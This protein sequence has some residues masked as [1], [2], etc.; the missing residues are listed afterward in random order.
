MNLSLVHIRLSL[1]LKRTN[2]KLSE[3]K[4]FLSL[5]KLLSEIRPKIKK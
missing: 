4:Q 3:N 5:I 2:S 1:S